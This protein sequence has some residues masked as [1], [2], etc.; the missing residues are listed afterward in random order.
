MVSFFLHICK[1]T[2]PTLRTSGFGQA[3]RRKFSQLVIRDPV[4]LCQNG[5]SQK[6]KV[7]QFATQTLRLTN[8]EIRIVLGHSSAF[9]KADPRKTI[10]FFFFQPDTAVRGAE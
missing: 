3:A 9:E 4:F 6:V 7:L 1:P 2:R 5:I 10:L 8:F